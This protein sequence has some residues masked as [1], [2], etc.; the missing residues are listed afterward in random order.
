MKI[1][2]NIFSGSKLI[3][4]TKM[5]RV[6]EDKLEERGVEVDLDGFCAVCGKDHRTLSLSNKSRVGFVV[7]LKTNMKKGV[8][9]VQHYLVSFILLLLTYQSHIRDLWVVPEVLIG[10]GSVL[11]VVPS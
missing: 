7:L 3:G 10:S 1:C 11:E 2:L 6:D 4:V 5:Q 9:L 8:A